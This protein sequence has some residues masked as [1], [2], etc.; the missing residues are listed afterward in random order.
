MEIDW[1]TGLLD[2]L[3][4]QW[5]GVL[6]PRLDALTD[7]AFHWEPV[8]GMWGVRRRAAARSALP[9]GAGD[10]VMD[11]ALDPPSPTPLTTIAWRLGHIA[12]VY[13]ERAANH[14]GDG[15][16]THGTTDWPLDVAGM[17]AL[18]DHWH[19]RWVAGV[20][21]LDAAG[22]ARPCGPAEGPYAAEP[23]ANLVLHINR[24]ILHHGA[25]V[26]LMM[27]LFAHRASLRGDRS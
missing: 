15:G 7:E 12:V 27:D 18:I 9:Q 5:D 16:V 25:E 11:F 6:R 14:F 19:D 4:F 21:S 26:A 23:L 17:L 2:Q 1:T 8:E 3:G 20:A 22:L 24:E 13:G 10:V